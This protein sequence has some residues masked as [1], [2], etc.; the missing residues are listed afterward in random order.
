M[1]QRTAARRKG[2]KGRLAHLR[3]LAEARKKNKGVKDI[4]GQSS[5]EL[6]LPSTS[7]AVDSAC[8]V[9]P[10]YNAYTS[11]VNANNI[12]TY[13]EIIGGQMCLVSHDNGAGMDVDHLYKMHRLPGVSA[14]N[15]PAKKKTRKR[16]A[17]IPDQVD[18]NKEENDNKSQKSP[19]KTV[20][21]QTSDSVMKLSG[22][23]KTNSSL[24]GSHKDTVD[25]DGILNV[26]N[27][28]LGK[29]LKERSMSNETDYNNGTKGNPLSYTTVSKSADV[30]SPKNRKLM[31]AVDL[32][33][34]STSLTAHATKLTR[35][36]ISHNKKVIPNKMATKD[37][38][39]SN[40]FSDE[41]ISLYKKQMDDLS[42]ELKGVKERFSKFKVKVQL[43]S[44]K[45]KP[46]AI[47]DVSDIERQLD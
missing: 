23:K 44:Q 30:S 43:L 8:N 5:E 28:S 10:F 40:Y 42:E 9:S 37:S 31:S 24:G 15:S 6:S 14:L 22:L 25:G 36:N 41:Q 7:A 47:C 34:L 29:N 13:K 20:L 32:E 45:A 26:F 16:A 39:N 27:V 35:Q 21:G 11:D 3:R 19:Q 17:K 4:V 12:I 46:R 18:L 1:K 2:K 38:G 33:T